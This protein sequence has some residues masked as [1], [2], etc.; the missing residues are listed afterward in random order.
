[1][2]QTEIAVQLASGFLASYGE[3]DQF[4]EGD[5]QKIIV[6]KTREMARLFIM[7]AIKEQDMGTNP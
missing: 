4:P 6:V 3:E 2:T 1:M 7:A 5:S